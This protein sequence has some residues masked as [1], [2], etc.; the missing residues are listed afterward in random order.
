MSWGQDLRLALPSDSEIVSWNVYICYKDGY[1]QIDI[2]RFDT[3]CPNID[4]IW[5]TYKGYVS[6]GGRCN[7]F[8]DD[9]IKRY[10][11]NNSSTFN[12][13]FGTI[14]INC[15]DINSQYPRINANINV[16]DCEYYE[17]NIRRTYKNGLHQDGAVTAIS[18][19]YLYD[20]DVLSI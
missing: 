17:C 4:T 14:T 6:L 10:F 3:E 9:S 15:P 16:I 7:I 18:L 20:K 11:M 12:G 2:W 13:S 5:D 19:L 1:M 8:G